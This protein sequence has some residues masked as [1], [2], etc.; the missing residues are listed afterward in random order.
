MKESRGKRLN[1][2]VD[3]G[4]TIT[5]GLHAI[6]FIGVQIS[7][8]VD[9]RASISRTSFHVDLTWAMQ[10]TLNKLLDSRRESHSERFRNSR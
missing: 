10:L 6:R 4:L 2:L 1:G 5:H 9:C 8:A 7:A 3:G